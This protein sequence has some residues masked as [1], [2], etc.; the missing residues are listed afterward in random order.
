MKIHIIGGGNLGVAIAIGISKYT[1]DNAVTITR[2]SVEK[3]QY[4]EDIGIIVSASNTSNISVKT[5]ST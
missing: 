1:T 3:I 5:A 2:R 4:L